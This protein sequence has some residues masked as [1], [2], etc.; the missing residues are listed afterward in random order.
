MAQATSGGGSSRPRSIS[1]ES[2]VPPKTDIIDLPVSMT[3]TTTAWPKGGSV[4][5]SSKV[6]WTYGG[7]TDRQWRVVSAKQPLVVT[8]L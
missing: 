2:F 1:A 5:P 8:L 6:N 3:D 4:E 7:E